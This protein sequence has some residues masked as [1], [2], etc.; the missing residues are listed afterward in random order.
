MHPVVWTPDVSVLDWIEMNVVHVCGEVSLIT[1]RVLPEP[2]LPD[3]AQ[4][5]PSCRR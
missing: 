4:S 3:A 1:D 5:F 2:L